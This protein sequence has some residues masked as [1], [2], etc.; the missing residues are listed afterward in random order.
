M[1]AID[2]FT[3]FLCSKCGAAGFDSWNKAM[4]D[5]VV[6]DPSALPNPWILGDQCQACTWPAVTCY[7][8]PGEAPR[9]IF[10]PHLHGFAY[11][12]K[13]M[14]L[15]VADPSSGQLLLP[16]AARD[17]DWSRGCLH[18]KHSESAI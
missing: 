4:F 2:Q 9:A 1:S 6:H 12:G 11:E 3:R 8:I 17:A 18:A 10:G 5:G 7:T 15:I 16:S 13:A 14:E